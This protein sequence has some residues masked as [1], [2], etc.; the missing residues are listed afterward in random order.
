MGQVS[1]TF[2]EDNGRRAL[3]MDKVTTSNRGEAPREGHGSDAE[4]RYQV[5]HRGV[6]LSWSGR[7][8]ETAALTKAQNGKTKKK[9]KKKSQVGSADLVFRPVL[10]TL[11][12]LT[13]ILGVQSSSSSYLDSK[14]GEKVRDEGEEGEYGSWS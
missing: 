11:L 10:V 6:S 1:L 3:G 12:Y 5:S 8:A 14:R 4:T 7:R 2:L 13:G 9:K